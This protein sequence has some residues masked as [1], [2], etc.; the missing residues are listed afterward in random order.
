MKT[1]AKA[2]TTK[3]NKVV[4]SALVQDIP[5]CTLYLR[6]LPTDCA[7]F[8]VH[9][10]N[11]GNDAITSTTPLQI[12]QGCAQYEATWVAVVPEMMF[13][14]CL[15]LSNWSTLGKSNQPCKNN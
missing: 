2:D 4:Q 1:A 7:S 15:F 12:L 9:W 5:N 10:H 13:V 14:N 6:S 3:T 8:V 11:K